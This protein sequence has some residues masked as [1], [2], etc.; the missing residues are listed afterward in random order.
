MDM[1]GTIAM[2]IFTQDILSLPCT[3]LKAAASAHLPSAYRR[4]EL[5]F[6]LRTF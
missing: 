3:V 4:D 5:S 2:N 1:P 6:S